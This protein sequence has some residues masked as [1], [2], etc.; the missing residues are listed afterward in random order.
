MFLFGLRLKNSNIRDFD[1]YK[2]GVQDILEKI[3]EK[4]KSNNIPNDNYN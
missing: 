2:V 4:A 1:K 3:I